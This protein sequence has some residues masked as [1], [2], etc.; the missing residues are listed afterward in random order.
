M[1][2][3]I[4][5]SACSPVEFDGVTHV[6]S[7]SRFEY[8]QK[9]HS[10]HAGRPA[11]R[12]DDMHS[13][14]NLRIFRI[15]NPDR[16]NFDGTPAKPPPGGLTKREARGERARRSRRRARSHRVMREHRAAARVWRPSANARVARR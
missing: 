1:P 16:L 4:R 12:V 9:R 13:I 14:M 7:R 15:A 3:E 11:G 10:T 2:I 5:H 8:T 6:A